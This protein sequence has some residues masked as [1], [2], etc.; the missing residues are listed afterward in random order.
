ML[1]TPEQASPS[2]PCASAPAENVGPELSV[3][4]RFNLQGEGRMEANTE[5]SELSVP[6]G[7]NRLDPE[8]LVGNAWGHLVAALGTADRYPGGHKGLDQHQ[9]LEPQSVHTRE[10]EAPPFIMAA[11]W[12]YRGTNIHLRCLLPW[13]PV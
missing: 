2:S 1:R 3:F 9:S 5:H 8:A 10:A 13:I 6:V 7:G 12:L 11:R 4:G